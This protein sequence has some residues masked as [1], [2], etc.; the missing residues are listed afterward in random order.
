[1]IKLENQENPNS[2]LEELKERYA[3]LKSEYDLPEFDELNKLFD[4]E[5]VDSETDFLLR[6]IRRVISEKVLGYLKF[7]EVILNPSNAPIFFF[8][9]IKKMENKDKD[10]LTKIYEDLGKIEIEIIVLDLEYSE[11]KEAEFVKKLYSM[12][13]ENVRV[14][15]LNVLKK[16]GNGS[17][18]KKKE[19]SGSYFG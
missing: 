8:T 5:E 1:M 14:E 7:I 16:I 18:E 2:N 11:K 12:C 3:E 9:L 17:D 15:L 6:R 10:I 4:I 13:N 19:S